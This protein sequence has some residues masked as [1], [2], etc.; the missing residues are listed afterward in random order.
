MPGGEVSL[1]AL[2]HEPLELLGVRART[3]EEEHLFVRLERRALESDSPGPDLEQEPEVCLP[4]EI[5]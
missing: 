1:D 4:P 2:L 5:I 3:E